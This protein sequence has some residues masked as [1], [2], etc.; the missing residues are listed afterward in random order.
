MVNT[1]TMSHYTVCLLPRLACM[2]ALY[3]LLT[4]WLGLSVCLRTEDT[5]MECIRHFLTPRTELWQTLQVLDTVLDP[6]ELFELSFM[7][8]LDAL[9]D[10]DGLGFCLRYKDCKMCRTITSRYFVRTEMHSCWAN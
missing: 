8:P 4:L 9:G 2:D 10:S 5:R 3:P 7:V 6:S 1:L